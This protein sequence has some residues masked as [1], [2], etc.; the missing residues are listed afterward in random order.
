MLAYVLS[1]AGGG[2]VIG[3]SP[4]Y[5]GGFAH[6]PRKMYVR[7]ARDIFSL[8]AD[9]SVNWVMTKPNFQ[10]LDFEKCSH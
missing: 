3:I 6:F 1:C 9:H 10:N 4:I 8:C 5:K 2:F 7:L